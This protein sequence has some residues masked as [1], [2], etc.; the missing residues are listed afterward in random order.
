L[1]QSGSGRQKLKHGVRTR[2]SSNRRAIGL[3]RDLD[4][5][6]TVR[7]AKVPIRVRPLRPGEDLPLIADLPGLSP[8]A[9]QER[10]DQRLLVNADIPTCWVAVDGD[11]VV[12]YM[13]W[14]IA[15]V[16]NARVRQWWGG[17]FP[18]LQAHEALLEGAYTADTHRG[19]G[20]MAHAMAEIAERAVDFGARQAITFVGPDNIGSLKGCERAGFAPYLERTDSWS[21]FRRSVR[22]QPLP[23][24]Q[25]GTG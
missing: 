6:F 8:Q 13:Q 11:D 3:R 9:A 23:A 10:I 17:L 21:I 25:S 12:C 20:I 5:P 2:F 24:T 15:A 7:A 16:D 19:L 18:V 22:F 1:L 4:A 14:L